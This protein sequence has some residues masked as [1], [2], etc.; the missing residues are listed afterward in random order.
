MGFE[1]R[2]GISFCEVSDRLLFLDVV[3]DRYFCLRPA[4]EQAFRT[5]LTD[6]LS[7]PPQHGDL[8]SMLQSGA[9]IETT[10][11]HA[12]C[13]FRI[14]RPASLSLLDAD[15]KPASLLDLAGALISVLHARFSLRRRPLHRIL[16]DINLRR[17]AWPRTDNVD[18]EAI[19]TTVTAFEATSR[20]LRSHDACLS[21]SVALAGY[22]AARGLPADLVIGVR[23]RPFC[24]HAWVQSGRWLL[25]D[26]IDAV[27]SYTP[28]L[29]V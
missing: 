13:P 4:T 3:A 15:Q 22:L 26:R 11:H 24:A 17:I 20:L 23:M 6:R 21:R 9:L 12:P 28:I 8:A 25:N 19:K 14:E 2:K 1:L 29:A 18:L 27:R 10:G 7:A 16:R 5:L